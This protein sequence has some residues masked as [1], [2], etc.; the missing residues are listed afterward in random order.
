MDDRVHVDSVEWGPPRLRWMEAREVA[1]ARRLCRR[2]SDITVAVG[3]RELAFGLALGEKED[4]RRDTLKFAIRVGG[5]LGSVE[6]PRALVRLLLDQV[7]PALSEQH[8]DADL[9]LETALEAPLTALETLL[10][11]RIA[12][13]PGNAAAPSGARSVELTVSADGVS[14]GRV[15]LWLTAATM[16]PLH[17]LFEGA[18]PAPRDLGDFPLLV[19]IVAGTIGLTPSV[20]KTLRRGD[21]LLADDATL[22]SPVQ[23]FIAGRPL[24]KGEMNNS[25]LRVVSTDDG[26]KR[27]QTLMDEHADSAPEASHLDELPMTVAFEVGRLEMTLGELRSI[28]PGYVIELKRGNAATIDLV[29]RGRLIGKAELVQIDDTVGARILRLFNDE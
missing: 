3:N 4:R 8:P 20:L 23:I 24:M 25:G 5:D 16:I 10:G 21:V 6:M 26:R 1:E 14:I 19:E 7:D 11:T 2:R 27:G 13:L 12:V 22:D 9:V 29:V 15:R 18:P 28:Q 17:D